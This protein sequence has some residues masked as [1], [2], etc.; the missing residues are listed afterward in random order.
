MVILPIR[1]VDWVGKF[2]ISGTCNVTGC[3][4]PSSNLIIKNNNITHEGTFNLTGFDCKTH[5]HQGHFSIDNATATVVSVASLGT[6]T[7]KNK[8]DMEILLEQNTTAA[9][10]ACKVDMTRVVNSTV[11]STT[12]T[13][14]TNHSNENS[15]TNGNQINTSTEPDKSHV[16]SNRG[17]IFLICISII[18]ATTVIMHI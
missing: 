14:T 10:P 1:T 15:T 16:S 6:F 12:T 5:G 13:T 4:C 8:N 11:A 9:K 3:C 2:Q 18:M 7:M 17:S